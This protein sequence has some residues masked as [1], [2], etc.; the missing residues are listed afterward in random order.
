MKRLIDTD[1]VNG[2]QTW[3]EHD[4]VSKETRVYYVPTLDLDPTLDHCKALASDEERTKRGMK[5]DWWHYGFVPD[6]I[7]LK[8]WIEEGIPFTDA[9][10]YNR[11][12][13]QPEYRYLKVTSKH[14]GAKDTQIFLA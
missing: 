11:K 3:H 7:R 1:P 6:S 12:L 5:E 9:E 4:P 8:W 2:I 13:N 14:H 10:A